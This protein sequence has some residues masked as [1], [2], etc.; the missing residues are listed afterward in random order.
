MMKELKPCPFCGG[1]F[2]FVGTI[3]IWDEC[4]DRSNYRYGVMCDNIIGGCG[5]MVGVMHET[6]KEAIEAWNRRVN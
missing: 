5:A 1:N 6:K 3:E 2:Q 4:N